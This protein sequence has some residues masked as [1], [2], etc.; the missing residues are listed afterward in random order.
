[1]KRR[2]NKKIFLLTGSLIIACIS[3]LVFPQACIEKTHPLT[4]EN[5]TGQTLQ[6][7]VGLEG[8]GDYTVERFFYSGDV[9][10]YET[11]TIRDSG[12]APSVYRHFLIEA[13]TDTGAVL[14]SQW[15]SRAELGEMDYT[16]AIPPPSE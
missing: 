10:A 14:F 1:M 2:G 7:Y 16:V 4:I 9:P 8:I 6:I 12:I 3:L 5:R 15:Y 13:R 11:V